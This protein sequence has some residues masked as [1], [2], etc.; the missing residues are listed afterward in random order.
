MG[1]DLYDIYPAARKVFDRATEL[2]G[3]DIRS[4]C[5]EGSVERLS[6]TRFAQPA[7][8]VASMAALEVLRSHAKNG[9]FTPRFAAGLSLGEA[10]AL[11]A[12]GAISFDDGVRFVKSRGQFMDEAA[13]EKPGMM[14]AVLGFPLAD[15]EKLCAATG[16]EVGNLNAPGQI[17][18]SGQ[19]KLVEDAIEK[20]REAG[21]RVIPLEVSGGFHSSCMEPACHRIEKALENVTILKPGIPVVSNLT[22]SAENAPAQIKQNLIWQMNHRT[23]WEDSMRFILGKGV[24]TFIEFSPGKVLKGLLRKIDPSVETISLNALEDFHALES[25]TAAR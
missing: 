16:A 4:I 19:K 3:F 20:L 10:T 8:F 18:I 7:I 15:V 9:N 25:Q 23:L 6:Q 13:Q 12:A 11:C 22:A 2:L 17:V 1:K 14:A 21:A 5:F 24:K